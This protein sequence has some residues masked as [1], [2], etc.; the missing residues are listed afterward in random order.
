RPVAQAQAGPP[1]GEPPLGPADLIRSMPAG[2]WGRTPRGRAARAAGLLVAA[3]TAAALGTSAAPVSSSRG[4]TDQ[5]A[6]ARPM[7]RPTPLA[8]A[9]IL[10]DLDTGQVL[11]ERASHQQ[12]PL[13]SLTKVMTAILVLERAGLG[14]GVTVSANAVAQP[15]DD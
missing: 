14:E 3:L 13:A 9:A 6:A 5:L 12:R 8:P 7:A 2:P 11:F 1:A 10:E 15:G 4:R